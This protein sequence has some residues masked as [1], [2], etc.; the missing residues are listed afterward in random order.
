MNESANRL[1]RILVWVFLIAVVAQIFLAGLVT[2]ARQITWSI[3]EGLGHTMGFLLI[4]MLFVAYLG[5]ASREVKLWTWVL[6]VVWAVQVYLLVIFLRES[7]P[8]V[9]A[10]H[11]V[12]ALA[13]F[14]LSLRLLGASKTTAA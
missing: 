4:A 8:Y 6:F 3:H 2:V 12:L 13:D 7:M 11:P 14:W 10:F 9:A 5:K 1:F